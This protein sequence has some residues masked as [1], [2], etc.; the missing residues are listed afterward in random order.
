MSI[1][2][3]FVSCLVDYWQ[4]RHIGGK[5]MKVS[6]DHKVA[7]HACTLRDVRIGETKDVVAGKVVTA[8]Y[9]VSIEGYGCSKTYRTARDA[10]YGMLQ[11]HACFNIRIKD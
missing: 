11:D 6:A 7:K 1:L 10:V 4:W 2:S 5:G 9:Y 3:Y 8:G